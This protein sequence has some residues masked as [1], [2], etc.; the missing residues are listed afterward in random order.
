MSR[1]LDRRTALRGLGTAMALPWLEAM[2]PSTL[3][4][5]ARAASAAAST[6]SRVAFIFLPNGV[7]A[8]E[9]LLPKPGGEIGRAHV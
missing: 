4:R 9:W 7:H 8:P 5:A 3:S 1:R 2:A 6:P